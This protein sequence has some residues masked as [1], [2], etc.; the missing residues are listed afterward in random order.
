MGRPGRTLATLAICVV[1]PVLL[2]VAALVSF[3][4][5]AFNKKRHDHRLPWGWTVTATSFLLIAG[6]L[7]GELIRVTAGFLPA[8]WEQ[9]IVAERW[10]VVLS[11]PALQFILFLAQT[12]LVGL[13]SKLIKDE[14][15]EWLAR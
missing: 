2:L 4:A 8:K 6:A 15:R 13:A 7:G 14:D 3:I 10:F 1:P 5:V 12:L 9:D 11:V